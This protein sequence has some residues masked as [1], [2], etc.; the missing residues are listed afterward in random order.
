M[1]TFCTTVSAL[2]YSSSCQ[3][4]GWLLTFFQNT[5]FQS[6]RNNSCS[7]HLLYFSPEGPKNWSLLKETVVSCIRATSSSVI[8]THICRDVLCEALYNYTSSLLLAS[9]IAVVAI[10]LRKHSLLS[11]QQG[12]HFRRKILSGL[13]WQKLFRWIPCNWKKNAPTVYTI[14]FH[15]H[16]NHMPA[17]Q[18]F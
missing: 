8:G 12:C 7:I 15:R 3:K 14:Y 10:H 13:K 17:T 4:N 1:S 11:C 18:C 6:S 16:F 2:V 5:I 9:S